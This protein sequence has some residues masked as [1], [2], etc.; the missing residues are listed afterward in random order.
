[1]VPLYVIPHCMAVWFFFM[2]EC[3][4]EK[5]RKARDAFLIGTVWTFSL[6]TL[7]SI[8]AAYDSQG[9]LLSWWAGCILVGMLERLI[10]HM[11]EREH[12]RTGRR[13]A[14]PP[15][16]SPWRE[17]SPYPLCAVCHDNEA[18]WAC[19]PCG[20]CAYCASCRDNL[21][22]ANMTSCSVCRRTFTHMD[23]IYL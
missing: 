17:G 4:T 20:H 13:R 14:V 16:P 22:R 8:H 6:C 2:L 18:Q 3:P 23:R 7:A 21:A 10:I 1:M 5:D 12:K 15:P 9:V 11:G 19:K